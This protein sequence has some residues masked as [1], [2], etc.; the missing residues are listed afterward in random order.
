MLQI[1]SHRND[2][3]TRVHDGQLFLLLD[4]PEGLGEEMALKYPALLVNTTDPRV[5]DQIIEQV[6]GSFNQ[7]VSLKPLFANEKLR[8]QLQN[9]YHL[10]GFHDGVHFNSMAERSN[11]IHRQLDK[12]SWHTNETGSFETDTLLRLM[13]YMYSRGTDLKPLTNRSSKIGYIYAYLSALTGTGKEHELLTI[14]GKGLKEGYVT[15]RL[16]D[17]VHVCHNCHGNYLNFR[18]VCTK[19]GSID[20]ETESVIHHFVCAHVGPESQFKKEDELECPKCDKHLRHIGIDYDKPSTM[21]TCKSCDHHF[22][23]PE[24][25]AR[26]IDCNT[27]SSLEQLVEYPI[28]QL[29]L[30]AAGEKIALKGFTEH[31]ASQQSEPAISQRFFEMMLRQEGERVHRN[32]GQSTYGRLR[33]DSTKVL[34]LNER[35]RELLQEEITRILSNYIESADVLVAENV[36]S[37]IFLLPDSDQKAAILKTNLLKDNLTKLLHDNLAV[38]PSAISVQLSQVKQGSTLTQLA[39]ETDITRIP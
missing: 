38:S 28:Y 20:L 22:Q 39:H 33:I 24:M 10:D 8:G 36:Q 6:R 32:N 9:H 37:Y 1:A 13:R 19:C 16:E 15:E 4:S 30:S 25:K 3:A 5:A 14:V 17:K 11:N 2:P 12:I 35:H 27:E 29:K 21:F 23:H 34:N 18:E 7:E 31:K 26:C